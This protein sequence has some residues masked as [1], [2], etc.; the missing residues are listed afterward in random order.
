MF[1]NIAVANLFENFSQ[2]INAAE[3]SLNYFFPCKWHD[4]RGFMDSELRDCYNMCAG[5][6][7]SKEVTRA[8]SEAGPER[9]RELTLNVPV[10][11]RAVARAV[12][13]LAAWSEDGGGDCSP[14][15]ERFL[16]PWKRRESLLPLD[17]HSAGQRAHHYYSGRPAGQPV[18]HRVGF[19]KQET[20]ESR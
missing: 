7:F 3:T 19:Q 12:R 9:R 5:C 8:L 4:T 10:E 18:G 20:Q 11:R 13:P 15:Q 17:A 16:L 6:A 14:S 2:I 1:G